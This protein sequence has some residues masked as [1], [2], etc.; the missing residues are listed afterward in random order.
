[1]LISPLPSSSRVNVTNND[2]AMANFEDKE[3]NHYPSTELEWLAT[4]TFNH[5]VDYYIQENDTKCKVWGEKALNLAQWAEDGGELSSLL[6]EKY[7][8]LTW[9]DDE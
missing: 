9:Q 1:M 6:L 5:A 4:T 3:P 7:S 8:G 2:V